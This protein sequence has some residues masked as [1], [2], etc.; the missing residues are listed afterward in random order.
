MSR[1]IHSKGKLL[2]SRTILKLQMLCCFVVWVQRGGLS[3]NQPLIAEE[4]V[5]GKDYVLL[6]PTGLFSTW[7]YGAHES[8]GQS[9]CSDLSVQ[10]QLI[11]AFC[12]WNPQICSGN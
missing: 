3:L 1:L 11:H 4:T 12:K 8:L 5:N 9:P 7:K 2:G 6:N 10:Q